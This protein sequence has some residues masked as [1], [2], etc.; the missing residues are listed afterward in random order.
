[1]SNVILNYI[2]DHIFANCIFIIDYIFALSY[3]SILRL[4]HLLCFIDFFRAEKCCLH[5]NG[6][7][8]MNETTFILLYL[9][10]KC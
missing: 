7:N 2:L 4:S 8:N 1:M 5:L 3:L 6:I 10:T 9:M